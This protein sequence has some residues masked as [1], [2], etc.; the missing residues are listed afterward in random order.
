[1]MSQRSFLHRSAVTGALAFLALTLVGC[2]QNPFFGLVPSPR[3]DEGPVIT[4]INP[5]DGQAVSG[6]L[7]VTGIASDKYRVEKVSVRVG[8]SDPVPAQ[9][10]NT[11]Y[12]TIDTTS[13]GEGSH[14]ITIIAVDQWTNVSEKPVTIVVDQSVPEVTIPYN[15][16][17]FENYFAGTNVTLSGAATD[18]NEVVR[19][20]ISL[21][22]GVTWADTDLGGSAGNRTWSYTIPDTATVIPGNGSTTMVLRVHDDAGLIGSTAL[23]V[24][25]DNTPPAVSIATPTHDVTIDSS[26]ELS[27]DLL[28]VSGTASD[29]MFGGV[30]SI[31][32][33]LRKVGATFHTRTIVATDDEGI[34]NFSRQ[35]NLRT[36]G[37]EGQPDIRNYGPVDIQVVAFDRAGNSTSTT[38]TVSLDD[39]PPEFGPAFAVDGGDLDDDL[40]KPINNFPAGHHVISGSVTTLPV[41]VVAV[42]VMAGTTANSGSVY[43]YELVDNPHDPALDE[44]AVDGSGAWS[45]TI[46]TSRFG[47]DGVYYLTFRVTNR[48]GGFDRISKRIRIDTLDPTVVISSPGNGQAVSGTNVS[49]TGHVSGTGSPMQFI[50]L[51]ITDDVGETP[52][53]LVETRFSYPHFT[54]PV[55]ASGATYGAYEDLGYAG[56]G[57]A[58][59]WDTTRFTIDAAIEITVTATDMAGNTFTRAIVVEQDPTA[60]IG[61]FTQYDHPTNTDFVEQPIYPGRFINGAGTIRGT[62][63]GSEGIAAV[64]I[65]TDNLSWVHATSFAGG[66]WELAL[67]ELPGGNGLPEGTHTIYLRVSDSADAQN[68]ISVGVEVD[69]S[70]PQMGDLNIELTDGSGTP[71]YHGTVAVTGTAID[72]ESEVSA[73]GVAVDGEE[74]VVTGTTAYSSDW[75]TQSLP[76][77]GGHPVI[78]RDGILVRATATDAAGNRAT[79]ERTV[80]V[81]PYIVSV[82]R[83]SAYLGETGIVIAGNNLGRAG[84][85]PIVTIGGGPVAEE[86]ATSPNEVTFTIPDTFPPIGGLSSGPVIVT[87]NGLSNAAQAAVRMDVFHLLT[88]NTDDQLTH[89]DAAYHDDGSSDRIVYVHAGRGDDNRRY[90]FFHDGTVSRSVGDF[91]GTGTRPSHTRIAGHRSNPL[92]YVTRSRSSLYVYSSTNDFGSDW[93]AELSA[94]ATYNDITADA[95]GTAHIAYYEDGALSYRQWTGTADPAPSAPVMI[96]GAASDAGEWVAIAVD[97]LN[98]PHVVY[99]DATANSLKYSYRSSGGSWSTPRTVDS[100]AAGTFGNGIAID[101][102]GG[103]HVSYYNGDSGNLMYAHALSPTAPFTTRIVDSQGITGWFSSIAIDSADRPHMTYASFSALKPRYARLTD[104]G[105]VAITIAEEGTYDINNNSNSTATVIDGSG[106]V[107]MIYSTDA[108]ELKRAIYLPQN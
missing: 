5:A 74:L 59:S 39:D 76:T 20:Q 21:D 7:V 10:T 95:T 68:T 54:T 29:N 33:N 1:M 81:R 25:F 100:H 90:T 38:I 80:N 23:L 18:D 85:V 71:Y 35:F 67:A 107:N 55:P 64:E 17:L 102:A 77:T 83:P 101:S 97:S 8:Q 73:I 31:V 32:V 105:F 78:A 65:S 103:I 50:D 94:S 82:S 70:D 106:Y 79:A 36:V 40:M 53:T 34:R 57:F 6:T 87:F 43:A 12:H 47:S 41:E 52:E 22:G 60:P 88:V 19:V 61:N 58:W 96:D 69:N 26:E 104:A 28:V 24:Y 48:R 75:N 108:G 92:V 27:D 66:V 62:A 63:E 42:E 14:T 99:H 37:P 30:G 4:I 13:L 16:S 49:V 2:P 51:V 3:D 9:G 56:G 45:Y 86:A 72:Y 46:D 11:W 84:A 89:P 44:G 91:P 93:G 98:R 15:P